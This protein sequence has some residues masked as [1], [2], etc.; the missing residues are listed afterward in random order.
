MPRESETHSN[1]VH[2]IVADQ[3]GSDCQGK[4]RAGGGDQPMLIDGS[5]AAGVRGAPPAVDETCGDRKRDKKREP[6][7]RGVEESLPLAF[8]TGHRQADQAENAS[9]THTNQCESK[10]RVDPEGQQKRE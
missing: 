1:G 2:Q 10:R 5:I 9:T 3:S 7:T 8:P 6:A 4:L